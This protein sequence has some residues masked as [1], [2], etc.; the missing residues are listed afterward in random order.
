MKQR[1]T[2]NKCFIHY[3]IFD[4]KYLKSVKKGREPAWLE[5]H[6]SNLK[7]LF[8][9]SKI[10][11]YSEVFLKRTSH[12][13]DNVYKVNTVFRTSVKQTFQNGLYKAEASLRQTLF[14]VIEVSLYYMSVC[15]YR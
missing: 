11:R 14:G 7:I 3:I 12:K 15:S 2:L 8:P 13:A 4:V 5:S 9:L 1:Q 6:I 10:F